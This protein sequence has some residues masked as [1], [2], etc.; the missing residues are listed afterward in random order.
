MAAG[1]LTPD[2]QGYINIAGLKIPAPL[3][4]RIIAAFRGMYPTETQGLSDNAVVPRVLLVLATNILTTWE[5]QQALSPVEGVVTDTR[6]QY[7]KAADAARAK[8]TTDA[9]TIIEAPV[10]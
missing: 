8:A 2:P 5:G 9:A 7:Q 10:P 4:V 6:K 1:G 3:A